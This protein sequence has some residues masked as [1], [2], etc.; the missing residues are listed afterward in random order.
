MWCCRSGSSHVPTTWRFSPTS[1]NATSNTSRRLSS[2]PVDQLKVGMRWMWSEGDDL[3]V[4]EVLEP[5]AEAVAEACQITP[6][7]TV[8]DVAAGT[9]NFALAAA[10]RGAIVTATDLT[11]L[12]VELGRARSAATGVSIRWA[13]ADAEQLP[14]EDASYD[15]VASGFGAMVAP[16]PQILAADA[17]RRGRTQ[18]HRT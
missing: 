5:H 14:Y 15:I 8:L 3:R 2:S 9:G 17:Y 12:M 10:R 18:Q 13:E 7:A 16:R 6:G 4:A 11:P 1:T